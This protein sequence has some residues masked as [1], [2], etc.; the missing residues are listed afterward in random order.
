[1]SSQTDL[2]SALDSKQATLTFDNT[3]T[4]NSNNPVQSKGIKSYVDTKDAGL[5]EQIDNLKAVGRF[6]ALWDASTGSPTSEPPS[7]PY[8]YHTGDYFRV[9]VSGTKIPTGTTYT[10]GTTGGEATHTLTVNEIPSH[11]HSLPAELT[12]RAGSSVR[13]GAGTKAYCPTTDASTSGWGTYEN[14]GS[15]AHNNMPPYLTVYMWKRIA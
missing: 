12:S 14:G 2:Q 3:P 8:T 13:V 15:Q 1:M 5:Q 10:A 4:V 7:S 11:A 6:L 9:S